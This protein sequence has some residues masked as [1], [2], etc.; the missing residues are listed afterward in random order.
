[1]KHNVQNH[2]IKVTTIKKDVDIK[3]NIIEDQKDIVK[4]TNSIKEEIIDSPKNIID[5]QEDITKNKENIIKNLD[6]KNSTVCKKLAIVLMA[7]GYSER[8]GSNKLLE[9]FLD[10]PLFT[11]A[12]DLAAFC[13]AEMKIIATRY[14]TIVQYVKDNVPTMNIVWNKH[15]EHGISESIHLG[16]QYLKQQKDYEEYVG[17]CF[18]V[19]DQPLLQKESMQELFKSFYTNPEGIHMCVTKKREGNPVIFPRQLFDELMALEGDKGGKRV[20]KKHP[21]LVHKVYVSEKELLD[22]DYKEDKINLEKEHN[23]R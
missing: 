17:C 14:E 22:M 9:S 6:K 2:I 23:M 13:E 5:N 12:V 15:P 16:I 21:E 3:E 10:K 19:C 18:M 7:S 8:F 20:A 4:D 1:M 11:Y